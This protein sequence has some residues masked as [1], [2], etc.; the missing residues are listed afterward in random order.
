MRGVS[1]GL[2]GGEREIYGE[3]ISAV[4]TPRILCAPLSWCGGLLPS[5]GLSDR[6]GERVSVWLLAVLSR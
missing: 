6:R 2:A 1:K 4:V 3:T 5:D